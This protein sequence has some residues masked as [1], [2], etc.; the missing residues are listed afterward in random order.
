MLT[1][2][3]PD[4][5]II[6]DPVKGRGVYSTHE[7]STGDL[8]EICPVIVLSKKD[9]ALIH[10]THLH[11]YYFTWDEAVDSIAMPLGYGCLYNH[12]DDANADTEPDMEAKVIRIIAKYPIEAGKE[13]CINYLGGAKDNDGDLWFEHRNT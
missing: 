2:Q 7:I 11:D 10:Q 9:K 1:T 6:E 12:A 13:I 3:L 8:I 4:L 5:Y